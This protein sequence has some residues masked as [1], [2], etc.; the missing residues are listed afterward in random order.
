MS[1]PQ[2][3]AD[4]ATKPSF[5]RGPRF[6]LALVL[7]FI[8][9]VYFHP[10]VRG[11]V[12]LAPG[13]GWS[14]IFGIRVLIGQMLRA[15]QGPLWN[16]YIF[17]GMPLLASIQ[18]GALYPPTWLFAVFAS[19]VAMNLLVI[20]TYHLALIGTY[21]FARRS[22]CN[23]VGALVA[24]LAFTFG[25]YMIGHLGHTNRVTAACW[26][27]WILLALEA[28]QQQ[29]RWR[30]I[31]LGALFI[32]LQLLAGEP[33]M[34]LYTVLTAGAYG[35]FTL[36][37]RLPREQR[38][39]FLG[40]AFVMASAS[41]LLSMVQLLPAREFLAY[42]DRAAIEYSYFSQFSY[43]P[44]QL[45]ELFFPYYFGGAALDPYRVP[46]WGQWNI[47]ETS[48]Y[49]GLAAWLL[50]LTALFTGRQPQRKLV[51]FWGGC[52]VVALLLACGDNLPFALNRL[53]FQ[54]PV[55]KLFRAPGRHLFEFTFALG[56]L[57]G[58]GVTA[59][60]T[61]ERQVAR[62]ALAL[63]TTLLGLI[64]AA[65]VVV[66]LYFDEKLVTA[67][68]LPPEAGALRNPDLYYPLIFFGLAVAAAWLYGLGGPG[69]RLPF[70]GSDVKTGPTKDRAR[71]W[72]R[73]AGPALI[74]IL[75][76]DALAWGI[77]F[78]WR[79]PDFNLAEQ[80]SD[81]PAVKFIKEHETDLNSFRLLSHAPQ[82]LDKLYRAL[83]YPNV[84]IVRGL[85][86]VNGYDPLRLARLAEITGRMTLDGVIAE[87]AAFNT[88]HRGF[89]LLNTKYL[90]REKPAG[91]GERK[92]VERAG[93][94]FAE[95]PLNLTFSNGVVTNIATEAQ[96]TEL[97]VI[98]M[99][100]NSD[101]LP[102]GA[103]VLR[104]KLH[105]AEGTVIERE[106]QAGRD[107]SEW[108]YDRE[109]VKARIQHSRASVIES[110]P[111]GGFEGH[112]YLTRLH[113]D[114]AR[115]QRLEFAHPAN[116]A[117]FTLYQA[118]LYDAPSNT[119][120]PL[121]QFTLAPDRWRKLGEFEAIELYENLHA[122]PRAWFVNRW[123]VLP[124]EQLLAA[125][126][127]GR[128]PDGAPFQPR[129]LALFAAEQYGARTASLPAVGTAPETLAT[130]THYEPNRLAIAT[131]N[132]QAGLLVLSEIYFRGW[133]A[134][135]DGQ[136]APIEQVNHVLRGLFV[137][138]GAHH[139][140]FV[141][142]ADSFR[143]GAWFSL[144]GVV[145]LLVG[146]FVSNHYKRRPARA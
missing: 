35:L 139:I 58:F 110:W 123:R 42:G 52:A 107:S 128:L 49:V 40:A 120:T 126:K 33:Q 124:T 82:P 79:L 8:P 70:S 50:A 119:S 146:A 131:N 4:S 56:M 112:R 98:S 62:R 72:R 94:Q 53:L 21:L 106:F 39:R 48:G 32:T 108:A 31:T 89:D 57:A 111:A 28:L 97:A 43:P 95:V 105:T 143:R 55:Y 116:N 75:L 44:R 140:E 87:P 68:P 96:A 65:A 138:A 99:L 74:G 67:I 100:A 45:F 101:S 47:V 102:N 11:Q 130:V 5:W 117:E 37:V 6:W 66:Y 85:Q 80:L 145:F 38:G 3:T 91:A 86:S 109:D 19:K 142:R 2:P 26:L 81:P 10:A 134:R 127:T 88:E 22:G 51:W 29:V 84:S 61:V 77:S 121:N 141:F 136:T 104:V 71:M 17:A 114:R 69:F 132:P 63:A 118:T 129:E 7:L 9:L 113:F 122:L 93:I 115:I 78:E 125:L 16:P 12:L 36:L 30:W 23:R 54:L 1:T 14:Q 83:D 135:I 103:P 133:E 144:A 73:L 90:L 24:G 92:L 20:S 13:D 15:G 64:V 25:G 41:V 27:P 76:A 137:P 34:T 46:Y 18:P 60:A 59:L